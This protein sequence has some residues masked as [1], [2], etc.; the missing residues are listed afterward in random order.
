MFATLCRSCHNKTTA[1]HRDEWI[2]LLEGIIKDQ[3]GGKSY[4]T[5]EEYVV[6]SKKGKMC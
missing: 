2:K 5:K 4:F 1:C 3:Y 6:Y